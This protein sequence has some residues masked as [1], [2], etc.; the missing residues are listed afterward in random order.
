MKTL[1]LTLVLFSSLVSAETHLLLVGGGKRP[2][3][4]MNE[5]SNLAGGEKAD[6]LVIPWASESTAGAEAI[7]S[8]LT[9]KREVIPHRLASEDLPALV[10]RIEE[11]TG[12]FFSGGN[13]NQLMSLIREYKLTELL[14]KKFVSGTIFGGTSA[15]TAIMSNPMLTGKGELGILDGS[16]I[17]LAEGLG[18]L[19]TGIIVDQ[20]FII[21]NRFNRLAGVVLNQTKTKGIAVDEGTS[22]LVQGNTARVIGP[23]QVLIFEKTG[24]NKL[25]ITVLAPNKGTI[26]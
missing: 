23:T 20:H 25:E 24:Q 22:L 16:Q 21:R 4:A 12:I 13:Q 9:G 17:E 18:L 8:E 1:L 3:E 2:T 10:K 14:K 7:K 6:I 11:C 5:F 26:L 19:P 15:G